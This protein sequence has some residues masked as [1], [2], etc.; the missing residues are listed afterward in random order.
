MWVILRLL[1]A[2][3]AGLFK[4]CAR[5]TFGGASRETD[6]ISWIHKRVRGKRSVHTSYFG[7]ELKRDVFFRL[8]PET[9]WDVMFK[10]LGLSHEIQ[11][12]DEEFDSRIYVTCDHPA[13]AAILQGDAAARKAILD[14]MNGAASS[15]YAD[16]RHIWV[17]C[18]GDWTPTTEELS[19]LRELRDAIA[20]IPPQDLRLLRDPFFWKALLVEAVAWSAAFYGVPAL[21]EPHHQSLYLSWSPVIALG[22][23]VAVCVFALLL[24]ATWLLLRGSSR[25]H[26]IFIESALVLA[27]GVPFSSIEMVA[28]ANVG[29]DHAAPTTLSAPVTSKYTRVTRRKRSQSTYYHVSL[30]AT[31]PAYEAMANDLEVPYSTYTAV[32]AGDRIEILLHPGALGI[33]WIESVRSAR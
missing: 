4:Y 13:F 1:A 15:I 29:F 7:M 28:D 27:I 32:K 6:G 24:A 9:R 20:A 31:T 10:N 5:V 2:A 3:V 23:V 22:L 11:G 30:G 33:P 25:A 21:V 18:D 19:C 16:G 26:R 12:G 17:K 14:L 8:T